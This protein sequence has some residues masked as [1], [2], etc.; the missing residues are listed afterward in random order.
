MALLSIF[1]KGNKKNISHGGHEG[2]RFTTEGTEFYTE[3]HGGRF[4]KGDCHFFV[5]YYDVFS[6]YV[7]K[8]EIVT[9]TIFFSKKVTS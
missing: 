1:V 5:L 6:L 7:K 8:T 3:V 9:V 4:L 2:R